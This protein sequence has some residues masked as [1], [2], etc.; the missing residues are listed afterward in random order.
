MVSGSEK[1][2]KNK[3]YLKNIVNAF[4]LHFELRLFPNCYI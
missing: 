1:C 2:L 4:T 3:E